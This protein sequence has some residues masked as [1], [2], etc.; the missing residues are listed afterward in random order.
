M[1][2]LKLGIYGIRPTSFELIDFFVFQ[3]NTQDCI[4][5]ITKDSQNNSFSHAFFTYI[6]GNIKRVHSIKHISRLT[7]VP[8]HFV[9]KNCFG[10]YEKNHRNFE[11]ICVEL[12]MDNATLNI[13]EEQNHHVITDEIENAISPASNWLLLHH[14]KYAISSWQYSNEGGW[15]IHET[16]KSTQTIRAI[17]AIEFVGQQYIAGCS[18]Q[19]IDIYR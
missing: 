5:V 13:V 12:N 8:L 15:I 1:F 19:S 17:S 14:N 4:V 7:I 18:E 2:R 3:L 9:D 16:I 11:T 10:R 6:N